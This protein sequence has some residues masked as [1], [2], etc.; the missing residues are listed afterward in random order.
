MEQNADWLSKILSCCFL[1]LS[2]WQDYFPDWTRG[3]LGRKVAENRYFVRFR[4]ELQH[5]RYRLLSIMC[6][7]YPL[8]F[9]SLS[10]IN[11]AENVLSCGG[12][13]SCA[14][15]VVGHETVCE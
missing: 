14:L 11:E 10:F 13:R 9:I 3:Q 4:A 6:M 2:F 5:I 15:K 12:E 1:F 7:L 8:S